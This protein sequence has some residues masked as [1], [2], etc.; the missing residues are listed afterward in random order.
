M[1]TTAKTWLKQG[2]GRQTPEQLA[3]IHALVDTLDEVITVKLDQSFESARVTIGK[4]E[5]H[6]SPSGALT[7][8]KD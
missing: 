4:T 3:M 8:A 1:A 7:L 6:L 2:R 5:F